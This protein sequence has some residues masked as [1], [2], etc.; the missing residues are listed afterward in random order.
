M[1]V[2]VLVLGARYVL[3]K[4]WGAV[5]RWHRM[6]RQ[7]YAHEKR[8]R[9]KIQRAQDQLKIEHIFEG[10]AVL[11][12]VFPQA[13]ESQ[14]FLSLSHCNGAVDAAYC[15]VTTAWAWEVVAH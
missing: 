9:L 4:S 14:I 15:A 3:T 6:R 12:P 13:T 7:R 2:L 10:L 5:A 8:E 11:R 1:T